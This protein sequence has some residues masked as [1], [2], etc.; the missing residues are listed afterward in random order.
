MKILAA[1]LLSVM[2]FFASD[3]LDDKC[4]INHSSDTGIQWLSQDSDTTYLRDVVVALKKQWPDNK[5]INL[6]FQG[7]SVPAGYFQT[8]QI[9]IFQSYPFLALKKLTDHF[10]TAEINCIRTAIGGENAEQGAKRFDSTVLNHKPDVLFIDYALNDRGIG[11]SRSLLAWEFMI[12][13]ALRK[14]IKLVLLT[15]TPDMEE[16]ITDHNAVLEKHAN[17][18]IALAKKYNIACIDSYHLFK[19]QVA[20][21]GVLKDYMAQSN[22][23]NQLGHQLVANEISKLFGIN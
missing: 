15:P 12:N 11:L 16:D 13:A 18:I 8:P 19:Q 1:A 14:N 17:Q 6:V 4:L 10:K 22:H 2:H 9:N 7:H 21:G 3:L 20:A 5:T 23:P